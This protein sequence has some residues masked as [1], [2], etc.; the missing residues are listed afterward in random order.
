MTPSPHQAASNPSSTSH[1]PSSHNPHYGGSGSGTA[2]V[3]SDESSG[4]S[5]SSNPVVSS[6]VQNKEAAAAPVNEAAAKL[7]LEL[8]QFT[9]IASKLR[10]ELVP[11]S[12][13]SERCKQA[14]EIANDLFSNAPTWVCFYRELMG[15]AGMLHDIFQENKDF[16]AF[17]RTDEH[18][19]LQGMLTALRSRD[20]PECD[21]NDPQRMITVRLPKSL[22]E[23]MCEEATRLNISVNRLCISRMLQ[24]LDPA[25]IPETNSKPRGRK[26]RTRTKGTT[27]SSPFAAEASAV[28]LPAN[29]A[30]SNSDFQYISTI[31]RP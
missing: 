13:F 27:V 26:P 11:G 4:S 19:Q 18:H 1:T 14:F 23:A 21:P 12:T 30:E 15:G 9:A 24:L 29:R 10:S 16:G 8:K 31:S 17:L 20:L 6:A 3:E 28:P 5:A 7:A 22:H 25:M 2:A